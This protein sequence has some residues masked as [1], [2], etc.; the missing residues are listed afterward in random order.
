[1]I[2]S[3]QSLK[4]DTI[5]LLWIAESVGLDAGTERQI[6]ELSKRLDSSRFELHLVTFDGSQFPSAPA[7]LRNSVALSLNRI[8]S[9]KGIAAVNRLAR[10]VNAHQ[11]DIVHGFMMKSSLVASAMAVMANP[12]V[13]LVS[14]RSLGYDY[15]WRALCI[16]RM[17]TRFAT[18]V[19]ANSEAAKNA[20][21][22]NELVSSDRIDVLYNGVDLRRFRPRF[23]LA[24]PLRA[25]EVQLPYNRPIVGIV[26]N[27]RPV[28]DLPLFLRAAAIVA[29]E[30]SHAHFLLVG[31]GTQ[32]QQ[33]RRMADELGIPERV[34]FT[35]GRGSVESYL[36]W[37]TIGCL[38]SRSEGFSNA[39]LE[40]MASEI[41]VVA[42]DV[43]GNR[44]AIVHGETGF[45][46][47]S[48]DPQAFAEAILYLLNNPAMCVR[49]G[50]R[51]R[52]RCEQM[53]NIEVAARDIEEYYQ[54]LLNRHDSSVD[55]DKQLT[56]AEVA[57]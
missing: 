52:A 43:G 9:I 49:F 44:E 51:A 40:Y 3:P 48:R 16:S 20:V 28:K 2:L 18:R 32:E 53:F 14:R 50:R 57:K 5:R 6:R 21:S 7:C 4:S 54:S 46:I 13:V 37:I 29:R 56:E 11:I 36:P 17:L 31:A 33:L 38:T 42:S 8:W 1:V 25:T 24:D 12:K 26:A 39:I 35:A 23:G 34:T 47:G 55:A 19:L 41:P 45:L 10:Y 22:K 30:S 27:Y 15:N